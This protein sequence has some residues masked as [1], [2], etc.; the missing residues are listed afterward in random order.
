MINDGGKK[1]IV[2]LVYI[3]VKTGWA[4]MRKSKYEMPIC[5]VISLKSRGQARGRGRV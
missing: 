4:G 5:Q 3:D 2:P 1:V